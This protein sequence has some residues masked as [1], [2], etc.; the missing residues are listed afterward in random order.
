MG[1]I[2]Q[3]YT[4]MVPTATATTTERTETGS[5]GESAPIIAPNDSD[6]WKEE[7]VEQASVT[8]NNDAVM[9]SLEQPE[10]KEPSSVKPPPDVLPA[11]I[12]AFWNKVYGWLS[13]VHKP[14]FDA[15]FL[16]TESLL[17]NES[18]RKGVERLFPTGPPLTL[19]FAMASV[20]VLD[21]E[22]AEGKVVGDDDRGRWSRYF[23]DQAKGVLLPYL[24]EQ[25]AALSAESKTI[26]DNGGVK[27]SAFEAAATGLILV[28]QGIRDGR[29]QEMLQLLVSL[30]SVILG[31]CF[32]DG[33]NGS[34]K[35]GPGREGEDGE[36]SAASW[37][38]DQLSFRLLVY[39]F[40][41]D[42]TFAYS[43]GSNRALVCDWSRIGFWIT[44]EQ[45]VFDDADVERGWKE[46]KERERGLLVRGPVKLGLWASLAREE[47]RKLV[48]DMVID[49]CSGRTSFL[50]TVSALAAAQ[51][52]LR[53][54]QRALVRKIK[55]ESG[56]DVYRIA[57][58]VT[59][60]VGLDADEKVYVERSGAVADLLSDFRA[61]LPTD[62]ATA[63]DRGDS[64]PL[65]AR[66]EAMFGGDK[67]ADSVLIAVISLYAGKLQEW[68]GEE[69]A[70]TACFAVAD[71]D[72]YF[73]S[74]MF[75][76]VLR[77]SSTLVKLLDS[78]LIHDAR[79]SNVHPGPFRGIL[80]TG[81]IA[82]AARRA[83]PGAAG[84]EWEAGVVRR[85]LEAMARRHW[86]YGGLFL[87]GGRDTRGS[88]VSREGEAD[89]VSIYF[90]LG[91]AASLP[92]HSRYLSSDPRKSS[93]RRTRLGKGRWQIR[94]RESRNLERS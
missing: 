77:T 50:W 92:T 49:A 46:W 8:G 37:V 57:G 40:T 72:P 82:L 55:G 89:E 61:A 30:K 31:L 53:L 5:S 79:L 81:A 73:E 16:P 52:G 10:S 25:R 66:A 62:L 64:L 71:G 32:S 63:L 27:M 70:M 91:Q 84:F 44:C 59:M 17:N 42:V 35:I 2:Q 94:R 88:V 83:S 24:A 18:L 80:D 3:T 36:E 86:P 13:I 47:R 43:S 7:P 15:S 28:L 76:D 85:Y 67:F 11:A 14:T 58:K 34:W 9:P 75:K 39:L 20:G 65:F 51:R 29:G 38:A 26:V 87:S 69:V 19:R 23:A 45:R 78:H 68:V 93:S 22:F 21:A 4:A 74:A 48:G 60:G 54:E 41:A 56:S 33:E 90:R 6:K 1:T 12:N